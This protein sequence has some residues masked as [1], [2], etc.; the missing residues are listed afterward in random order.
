MSTVDR[1][2]ERQRRKVRIKYKIRGTAERPRLCV[3]KSLKHIYAQII[4]D[5]SGRTIVSASTLDLDLRDKVKGSNIT[6]AKVVGEAIAKKALEKGIEKVV[7]DR[8]GYIYHGKVKALADSARAAG[9][10]F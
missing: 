7:F 1:K 2:K 10:K 6:S 5:E 8:N 4:D 9:L 3:Y